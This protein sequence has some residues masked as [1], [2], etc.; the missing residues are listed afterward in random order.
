MKKVSVLMC[1][2]K[3][4]IEW[5]SKAIDSI[6][7]QTYKDIELIVIVDNP[8]NVEMIKYLQNINDKR[9]QMFVNEENKGLV[10]SLNRGLKICSGEYIARMDADDISELD[11]IAKQV[12]YLEKNNY[13]L[14]GS[15]FRQFNDNNIYSDMILPISDYYCKKT[16]LYG[17]CCAHPSWIFKRKVLDD[18]HEYRNVPCCED[19]D[20]LIRCS[21]YNYK[22]GN[23]PE[24]LLNYRINNSGISQ[25]NRNKQLLITHFLQKKY[26]KHKKVNIIELNNYIDSVQFSKKRV[27][28]DKIDLEVSDFKNKNRLIIFKLILHFFVAPDYFINN[29]KKNIFLKKYRNK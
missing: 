26:R 21:L 24:R 9:L 2:Y 3:E 27:L 5:F 4:P 1:A 23:I 18:L 17:S 15:F 13:D 22:I 7:N 20:F 28:Y 12:N 14:I 25:S 29:I 10:L 11:R 6:L 8:K 19:Y 16:L